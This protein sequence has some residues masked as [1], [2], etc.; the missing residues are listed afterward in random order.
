MSPLLWPAALK[1]NVNLNNSLP[2]RF[3]TGGKEGRRNISDRYNSSPI[4][5]LSVT[6]VEANL[7]QFHPFGSPVYVLEYSPQSQKSY[8]KWSDRARVGIFMCHYP[9]YSN[10]VP[11]VFNMQSSNI[12]PQFHCIYDD[13]FNTFK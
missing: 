7:D 9:H 8:H 1:N 4:S 6:E 10:S 3:I 2:T 5:R 13:N 12:S 11:L